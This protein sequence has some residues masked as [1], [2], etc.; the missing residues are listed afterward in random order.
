[1]KKSV[2][3]AQFNYENRV[4]LGKSIP[5]DSPLVV[6]VEPSSFCNLECKFCPQHTGKSEFQK[7]NMTR[8]IFDKLLLDIREFKTKP[9][10]M[11]FC[12]IGD[13]LFNKHTAEFIEAVKREDVVERTELIT[14]GLLLN[15]KIIPIIAGSLD[16]IVIS[17]EGLS[18]ADYLSFTLKKINFEKFVSNIA[19]L[20]SISGRNCTVHI[21]I[22]NQSVLTK[23]R[24]QT[25]FKI[26]EGISDEIYIENLVDLWPEKQS[27]LGLDAGHRFEGGGVSSSLV[28][29]QIF[30]SMQVNADGRVLPCCVDWKSINI[31]GD[32]KNQSLH[33]IW[34][35][36]PIM[37]LRKRHLSGERFSFSPCQGCNHNEY[38]EKD[39][40]DN[41][42]EAIYNLLF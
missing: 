33:K 5:L 18:S 23:D 29:P 19:S 8:E 34:N 10:L 42:R 20:Y 32:V 37:E 39:N 30:K 28:C 12:G 36:K 40:I 15:E 4:D 13:P 1:M 41:V 25:F 11:R 9:K 7:F 31:V 24:E 16:R 27:N 2:Y 21:K 14:N 17:V 26:F 38:S 3:K 22:H 6:Y 35:D